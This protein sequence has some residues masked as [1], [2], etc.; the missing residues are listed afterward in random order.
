MKENE[1]KM[2]ATM[3]SVLIQTGSIKP[4]R[5]TVDFP[6]QIKSN[7]ERMVESLIKWSFSN[8]YISEALIGKQ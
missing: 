3:E 7:V 5:R 4:A 2:G 8:F 1:K 6:I